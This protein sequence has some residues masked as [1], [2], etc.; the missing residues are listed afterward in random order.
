MVNAQYLRRIKQRKGHELQLPVVEPIGGIVALSV[1]GIDKDHPNK[2]ISVFP[3]D[4]SGIF[5]VPVKGKCGY[6]LVFQSK[7]HHTEFVTVDFLR[8]VVFIVPTDLAVVHYDGGFVDDFQRFAVRL[9][10]I[11]CSNDQ[12]DNADKGNCRSCANLRKRQIIRA[13]QIRSPRSKIEKI[14][15]IDKTKEVYRVGWSK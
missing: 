10:G 11:A 7:F 15:D 12:T 2:F 14:K 6:A 8:T 3:V 4:F 9:I 5:D 1:I 13:F